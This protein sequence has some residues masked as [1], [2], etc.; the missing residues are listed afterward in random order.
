M[1]W[2]RSRARGVTCWAKRVERWDDV[3]VPVL[4]GVRWRLSWSRRPCACLASGESGLG[5]GGNEDLPWRSSEA[6]PGRRLAGDVNHEKG[7]SQSV[8]STYEYRAP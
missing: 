5:E 1:A 8:E 6:S 7:I 2:T 3:P 4:L